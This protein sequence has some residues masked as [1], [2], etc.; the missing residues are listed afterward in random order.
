MTEENLEN[1]KERKT[2]EG[3]QKIKRTYNKK[4]KK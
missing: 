3:G 1:K 4:R 2:M